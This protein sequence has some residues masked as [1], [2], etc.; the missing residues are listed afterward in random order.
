MFGAQEV[1]QRLREHHQHN[2]LHC[3]ERVQPSA[4]A[5]VEKGNSQLLLTLL[6]LILQ[7][8]IVW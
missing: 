7:H 8:R 4:L 6:M 5:G 1:S 2:L 3:A